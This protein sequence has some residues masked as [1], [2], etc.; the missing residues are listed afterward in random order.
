M[1]CSPSFFPENT[2][3]CVETDV[4]RPNRRV[5][6]S[7]RRRSC[8]QLSV[9]P[10]NR[11]ARALGYTLQDF[12]HSGARLRGVQSRRCEKVI[13]RKY[14]S[15]VNDEE[16][17]NQRGLLA[18]VMKSRL[19]PSPV[20][21]R[22]RGSRH[23]QRVLRCVRERWKGPEHCGGGCAGEGEDRSR[24]HSFRERHDRVYGKED[25]RFRRYQCQ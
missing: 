1:R 14:L 20:L 16:H 9:K 2:H 24:V 3:V 4:N 11:I 22:I 10:Q 19:S 13:V 12:V 7:W 17:K 8:G 5:S 18:S 6:R 15:D 23:V 21:N 25:T